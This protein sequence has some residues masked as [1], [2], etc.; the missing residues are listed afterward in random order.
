MVKLCLSLSQTNWR[1][2]KF[3]GAFG[4]PLCVLNLYQWTSGTEDR[5]SY[6][7][8]NRGIPKSVDSAKGHGLKTID[9]T[10]PNINVERVIGDGKTIRF[11]LDHW[12]LDG[13]LKDK[14]PILFSIEPKKIAWYCDKWV[15]SVVS[16]AWNVLQPD[17]LQV[18]AADVAAE[19]L[20][21]FSQLLQVR[22]SARPDV[23]SWFGSGAAP[24]SVKAVKSL[25][26]KHR[27]YEDGQLVW[28]AEYSRFRS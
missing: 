18:A 12:I 24:Y 6:Q 4:G 3:R 19:W 27:P 15:G 9:L 5:K 20:C 26:L 22:I 21:L 7:K 1:V 8:R 14:F 17:Q 28:A 25:M 16:G 11:W 10:V 23:W 2:Y 13:P